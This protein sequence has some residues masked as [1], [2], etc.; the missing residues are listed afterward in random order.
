MQNLINKQLGLISGQQHSYIN[1]HYG[2]QVY[3]NSKK[4]PTQRSIFDKP[5]DFGEWFLRGVR[6]FEAKGYDFEFLTD[7]LVAIKVPGRENRV[8][9]TKA[10]FKR[11]WEEYKVNYYL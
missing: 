5:L 2:K 11:E 8:L 1:R 9:R 3:N 4:V 10:D 7:E 6:S